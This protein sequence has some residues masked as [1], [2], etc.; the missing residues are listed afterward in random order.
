MYVCWFDVVFFFF[1]Q[2]TAYEMRISDWSSD[3]CSSDL[4][5][6]F[7]GSNFGASIRNGLRVL[8]EMAFDTA[9][10]CRAVRPDRRSH[11]PGKSSEEMATGVEA[12][13]DFRSQPR[14]DGFV[15]S[16]QSLNQADGGPRLRGGD[17]L[18][19]ASLKP[20]PA[21]SAEIGR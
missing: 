11:C 8:Q 1:K 4:H 14:M 2:K 3:V 13:F 12:A 9:R 19:I 21:I 17:A 16:H 18:F 15:R 6:Q 20:P 10:S 5:Q 7:A